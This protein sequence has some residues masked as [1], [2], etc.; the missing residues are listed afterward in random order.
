MRNNFTN[1]SQI[2]FYKNVLKLLKKHASIK[3]KHIS[4]K[5][6]GILPSYILNSF[7]K[8][9]LLIPIKLEKQEF[10]TIRKR[11]VCSYIP[12]DTGG[13][14]YDKKKEQKSHCKP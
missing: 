9:M 14:V 13:I 12:A 2:K 5:F 11:A 4:L 7:Q 6:Q 3:P 10:W 1:Y 8:S